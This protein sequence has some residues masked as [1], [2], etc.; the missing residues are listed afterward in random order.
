MPQSP[1]A[2][3]KSKLKFL[4]VSLALAAAATLAQAQPYTGIQDAL[5]INPGLEGNT[6][7]DGWY[8]LTIGS[9]TR[10]VDGTDYTINGLSGYPGTFA[11]TAYPNPI[12]SQVYSDNGATPTLNAN[13]NQATGRSGFNK[14]AQ[15]NGTGG[16]DKFNADGT[17]NATPW[18]GTGM[19][20]YPAGD[21]IYAI[22]F[23]NQY[24][25]KGGSF[26]IFEAN[27]LADL[28]T[29]VLQIEIGSANGYDFYRS[30]SPTGTGE[31]D[32]GPVPFGD[33]PG[34]EPGALTLQVYFPKLHLT[35]E[36]DTTM[37]LDADYAALLN[38]GYNGTIPM[39]T[40]PGG[41]NVDEPI[42]INLYGFQWDLS[43]LS[44]PVASYIITWDVAEHS[45][46]YA[47]RV[48]QADTFNPE[49]T[50]PNM[51]VPEPG[52]CLLLIA[53]GCTLL[54]R[55]RRAA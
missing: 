1:L 29:I 46:S 4:S 24:N 9:K 13:N 39:P 55:R 26:G 8:N 32:G 14:I 49:N 27:P 11:S 16:L 12:A 35:L 23:S 30:D 28:Q 25:A 40:G 41:S 18:G 6:K 43:G 15:A 53:G 2:F 21:S 10:T 31:F 36:D 44:S 19:G 48:T 33:A 7:D 45:Q 52:T 17:R 5:P 51:V 37:T 22:S 38:K 42:W 3:M 50:V 47:A 54:L 20:P 34:L